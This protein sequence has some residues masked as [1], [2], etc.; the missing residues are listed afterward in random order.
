VDDVLLVLEY[1]GQSGGEGDVDGSGLVDVDDL[2][3]IIGAFGEN[4]S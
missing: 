1:Y 2:L 4:C 3:V